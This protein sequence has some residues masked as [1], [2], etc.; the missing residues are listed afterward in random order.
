V[1]KPQNYNRFFPAAARDGRCVLAR[2]REK[3]GILFP[4]R[5]L[6]PFDYVYGIR[7][8]GDHSRRVP[9]PTPSRPSQHR[10]VSPCSTSEYVDHKRNRIAAFFVFFD[11]SSRLFVHIST[12]V[13]FFHS[14][15]HEYIIKLFQSINRL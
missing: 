11:V 1:C 5:L 6:G 4:V 14:S 12:T 10:T 8:G 15:D 3:C 13:D 2:G 9:L 7:E